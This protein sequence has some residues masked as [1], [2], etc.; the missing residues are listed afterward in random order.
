MHTHTYSKWISLVHRQSYI[1]LQVVYHI[2]GT[3][4]CKWCTLVCILGQFVQCLC[5]SV[6]FSSKVPAYRTGT[7]NKARM[8]VR[9][10]LGRERDNAPADDRRL[11]CVCCVIVYIGFDFIKFANGRKRC[12][13]ATRY[14]TVVYSKLQ[15]TY[16]I[17]KVFLQGLRQLSNLGLHSHNQST[18]TVS[19]PTFQPC[20]PFLDNAD[21]I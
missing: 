11:C 21:A 9:A 4:Y 8:E 1:V 7:S 10:Y 13:L 16:A 2:P 18:R 15:T 3:M 20:W 14:S 17:S 6:Q 12:R 5:T 19:A